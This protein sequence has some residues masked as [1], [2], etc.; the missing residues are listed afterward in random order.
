MTNSEIVDARLFEHTL[1]LRRPV[2]TNHGLIATRQILLLALSDSKGNKGWGEAAPLHSF[3]NETLEESRQAILDWLA[4]GNRNEPPA[5]P[6]ARA[7]IDGALLHLDAQA[8][9]HPLHK[10]LDMTSPNSFPIS[11]LL[12]GRTPNE[13]T[14]AAQSAIERGYTTVKVKIGFADIED[15]DRMISALRHAVGPGV[16]IRLDVNGAWEKKNAINNLKRLEHLDIQFVEEP[17]SG[18][19]ALTEVRSASPIPIAADETAV[20]LEDVTAI[21]AAGAA[22]I[23]VLKPSAVGG[24]VVAADIASRVRSAGLGLLITSLFESAVGVSHAAHLS[25]AIRATD[26]APGLSTFSMMTNDIAKP[27]RLDRGH[28]TLDLLDGLPHLAK[29][30]LGSSLERVDQ[31]HLS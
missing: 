21:I 16:N 29:G 10:R 17:V 7:A 4:D 23:I 24:I 20:S 27:P 3:T 26:L 2:T 18:I 1:R 13:I 28:L 8:A 19:A 5:L 31:S 11:I 25:S 22:D 12:S 30:V 9:G 14:V 6:T 15:D